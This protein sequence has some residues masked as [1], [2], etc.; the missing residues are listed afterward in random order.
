[1]NLRARSGFTLVELIVTIV[2]I[3]M[4]IGLA[5]IFFNFS[6]LSEKKVEDE[7]DLQASMRQASEVLN[8]TI[9]NAT[10]TFALPESV[11]EGT[12]K[13]KWNYFGLEDGKEIV[14]YT[15]DPSAGTHDRKV[16]LA[17]DP[18]IT[19]S[20]YFSQ[21][22]P[23]SKMLIFH[24]SCLP[25]GN[26]AKKIE[27]ETELSALNSVAVDNGGSEDNP[28]VAIAYR[29]DPKPNP[30]V[31][32][33]Q[34][35]VTIAITLVLDDSGSM[36]FDMQGRQQGSH[37]FDSKNVRKTI[38]KAQAKKLIGDFAEMGNV[39][40][41]II[42]FADNADRTGAMLSSTAYKDQ[43]LTKINGL[44]A[45]GGT[46]TGDGLRRAYY[47]LASY[48]TD[49][50]GDEIVNY[51]IL[52]TDGNPTYLSSMNAYSYDPQTNDE[53]C[54]NV[55]GSGQ[56]T[57][58]NM[59]NCMAYVNKI[60][61]D[62]V[63]GKSIDIRTFV[64]GF[65][66]VSANISRAESIALNACTSTSPA[67]AMTRRGTYYAAGSDIELENVFKTI[68]STILQETWHIYGPY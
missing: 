7:Y 67:N 5:N 44:D 58:T 22:Q 32:S 31:I 27:I 43:L 51:I 46:N 34:E 63:V 37:G 68:K 48:N 38:M 56:E 3:G 45:S 4:V 28:A 59:N 24:L 21:D 65:S 12:K 33:T 62:L 23:G 47:K 26:D 14:Q 52:L 36:D 55:N 25:D 42:P 54:A 50:A 20:L 57:T 15:W 40:I 64:I 66:A 17:A 8:N 19:Y 35:E 2:L 39:M 11:F 30:E 29:S 49:N 18:G 13:A 53:K 1:M 60:G 16:L 61:Q 9:R 41:S 6:F 10:V